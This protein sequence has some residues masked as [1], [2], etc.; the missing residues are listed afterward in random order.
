MKNM[1]NVKLIHVSFDEVE[2]FTPRVPQQRCP[3]EDETIPRICVAPTIRNALWAI[4]QSGEVI[5]YMKMLNLPVIIHAYY[6]KCDQFLM[7]E[8]IVDKVPDA[9]GTKEMWVT[10]IP[11]SVRRVDFELVDPLTITQKDMNGIC[12]RI[13]MGYA[14]LNRVKFQDN[15]RN[16]AIKFINGTDKIEHFMRNKPDIS[17][18]TFMSNIDDELLKALI[19]KE[20]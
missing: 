17:Y 1:K 5:H 6:I 19:R 16:L 3:N 2:N 9:M 12:E 18:R 13:V 8:E 10:E 11:D 7:P 14:S 4:P 15:W 20:G